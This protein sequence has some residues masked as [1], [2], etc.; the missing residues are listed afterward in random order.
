MGHGHLILREVNLV[1]RKECESKS[2][3]RIKPIVSIVVYQWTPAINTWTF[4]YL[5]S[6]FFNYVDH[7]LYVSWVRFAS[8]SVGK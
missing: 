5:L 8:N 7:A 2:Y 4:L 1:L 6:D 3:L